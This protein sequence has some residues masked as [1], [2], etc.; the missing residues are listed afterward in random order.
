MECALPV[1]VGVAT[2]LLVECVHNVRRVKWALYPSGLMVDLT[3]LRCALA[4]IVVA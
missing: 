3:A 2:V 1:L 4:P